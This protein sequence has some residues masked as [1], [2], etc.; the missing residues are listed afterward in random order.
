MKMGIVSSVLPPSWSGQS[1]VLYRLLSRI[2]PAQYA[3]ISRQRY[4][5]NETG[6]QCLPFLPVTYHVADAMATLI[7]A[8]RFRFGRFGLDWGVTRRGRQIHSIIRRE[9][10]DAVIACSGDVLDIPASWRAA[11]LRGIPLYLYLFDDYELQW[12]FSLPLREFAGRWLRKIAADV[13]CAIC[14]CEPLAE[15]MR[16]LGLQTAIIRNPCEEDAI[17]PVDASCEPTRGLSYRIV[18]TGAVYALNLDAFSNLV[19]ALEATEHSVELHLYTAQSEGELRHHGVVSDKLHVHPHVPP[20][21]AQL[22][23]KQADI[24]FLPFTFDPSFEDLVRTSATGKLAD[25]LASGR[26]ILAHV[27]E[28][29]Y[30]AG[31]LKT[32]ACGKVVSQND[33]AVLAR[34]ID[35]LIDSIETSRDF[36]QRGISLAKS[37][38]S[39]EI[40]A[41]RLLKTVNKQ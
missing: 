9:K 37:M 6:E 18:F 17:E 39:P 3:L 32:H 10:I 12:W 38:F 34:H 8:G 7:H 14:P 1:V 36:E 29:S 16:S 28:T 4:P 35:Q 27:P 41:A 19:S 24:L 20:Q 40:M 25:Y 11:R 21:E 22:L 15:R 5:R 26:P 23:Q 30:V 2:D 13:A 33:P 31:F